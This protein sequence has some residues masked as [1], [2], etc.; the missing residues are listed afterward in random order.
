MIYSKALGITSYGLGLYIGQSE[1]I[2]DIITAAYMRA[3]R[4]IYN[5]L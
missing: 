5:C 3:N 1:L 2:K 4:Q